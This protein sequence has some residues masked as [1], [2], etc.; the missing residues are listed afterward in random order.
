MANM[1]QSPRLNPPFWRHD[2]YVLRSLA[3]A[4]RDS[5]ADVLPTGVAQPR[6]IDF[7]AG[8]SP[9]R[10]LFES[11]GASYIACDIGEPR[12]ARVVP[13]EVGKALPF[14]DASAHVVVSFQVLEHVWDLDW[15]LGEARRLL[16][17]GGKLLLSTHGTW[18]YH[19]HPTDFRRWTRPGLLAELESRG[20]SV[21]NTR[22][23]VGPLAWTTQFRAFG[24]HYVLSSV[25]VVGALLSGFSNT[26][27]FLKMKFEDAI[28]PQQW[29]IDNASTYLVIAEHSG[30]KK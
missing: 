19:P 15:Y 22:A 29:I 24:W 14:A 26:V 21:I 8:D 18:L 30:H 3:A 11:R 10:P 6:V 4:V 2:A 1:D 13:I 23:L 16:A 25:P 28:T 27:H 12:D 9:Y 7:G 20:F 17:P 5:L